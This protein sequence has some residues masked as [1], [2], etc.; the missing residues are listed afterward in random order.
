M[1]ADPW[2]VVSTQPADPWAV[3]SQTPVASPKAAAPPAPKAPGLDAPN[4]NP[5]HDFFNNGADD[6]LHHAYAWVKQ[7]NAGQPQ[8]T[9]PREPDLTSG[10]I[11]KANSVIGSD[12][13]DQIVHA[14]KSFQ[15]WQPLGAPTAHDNAVEAAAKLA[16]HALGSQIDPVRQ[17]GALGGAAAQGYQ[18]ALVNKPLSQAT[19]LPQSD[20]DTAMMA[21]SPG[22]GHAPAAPVEEAAAAPSGPQARLTGPKAAD[23]PPE[24]PVAARAADWNVVK[25]EPA[26]AQNDALTELEAQR[27]AGVAKLKAAYAAAK[28]D[29]PLVDTR[30][31]G[32]QYHGARGPI[33]QLQEGYYSP[34][35][36]YGGHDTFYTTDATD[37][38]KGYGRKNPNST[39]YSVAE[40]APVNFYDMEKPITPEEWAKLGGHSDFM[41]MA[42][43]EA[44]VDGHPNLRQVMDEARGLSQGEGLTKDDVQ[45]E[46]D[47]INQGLLQQGYGGMTHQGGLKTGSAPHT[48]KIYFEPWHQVELTPHEPAVGEGVRPKHQ[49]A[50]DAAHAELKPIQDQILAERAKA[51]PSI[52]APRLAADYDH[53]T[54][55]EP[56]PRG[57]PGRATGAPFTPDVP[58]W[59]VVKETPSIP[60]E[61]GPVLEPTPKGEADPLGGQMSRTEDALNR[62]VKN[63]DADKIEAKQYLE[64]QPPEITDP[65]VQEKLYHDVEGRMINPDAPLSPEVQAAHEAL[66]PWKDEEAQLGQK[67]AGMGYGEEH[68]IDPSAYVHRVAQGKG[69]FMDAALDPTERAGRD[70]VMGD[71]QGPGTRG[72]S[73]STSSQQARKFFVLEDAKGNRQ[74]VT[75]PDAAAKLQ[76][77]VPIMN[78]ATLEAVTPKPATTAE[79]EANTGYR[80][81][82]NALVN[83]VDN[84]LRLRRAARNAD[85]LEGLKGQLEKNGLVHYDQ[86]PGQPP[87]DYVRVTVPQFK[88]AFADPRI[89]HILNDFHGELARGGE[90]NQALS[91]INRALTGAIFITPI[92]HAWNVANHWAVARGFDWL[93]PGGYKSLMLDGGRAVRAVLTQNED[94]QRMLREG[95]GLMY[96]GVANRDFHTV[97]IKKLGGEILADP[98]GWAPVAKMFGFANPAALVKTI[99]RLSSKAL[100]SVNDMFMLQRQFELMRKGLPAREAIHEA[101]RDI[102]NYR[103]PSH[104]G[105]KNPANRALAEL[106]KNPNVLMFG[107]Y[108]YGQFRAYA[109]PIKDI[110]NSKL[111]ASQKAEA[112]GKLFVM[113][114]MATGVYPILDK[115]VQKLSGNKDASVHRGGGLSIPSAIAD[116]VSGKKSWGQM[117]SSIAQPSPVVEIG[118]ELLHGKDGLGRNIIEPQSSLKGKA[119]Q[120]AEYAASKVAPL[121]TAMQM[122]R[123]GGVPQALGNLAAI[124]LPRQQTA[125]GR[126]KSVRYDMRRAARREARDPLMGGH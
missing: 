48:V 53:A 114:A 37:V 124:S 105:G 76:S 125:V 117:T 71:R 46:F 99:Y 115:V 51:A 96:G 60:G 59:K 31:Q 47:S 89:A 22:K 63:A 113:A 92:P 8:A 108:R 41:S 38:A 16:L 5:V 110:F 4:G 111:S 40:K 101:E 94:Y 70:P 109:E 12:V 15:P 68:S 121:N 3:Q 102:P 83:T 84:V 85:V 116:K 93:K 118:T 1:A 23:V 61:P 54:A 28:A 107:R 55:Q 77:G 25:Q 79:I 58:P 24:V 29:P 119:A 13:V 52:S 35:N 126:A 34:D 32:V 27:Q 120:A 39:M 88:G 80:Y 87:A 57:A 91:K 9:T 104:I 30:G 66:K 62:L 20:I 90:L 21:L 10:G 112:S 74:F 44:G 2:A 49:A 69:S 78:P 56:L 82:K 50:I 103:V 26:P 33:D 86:T 18:D 14:A 95:S 43:D 42:Y 17:A 64:S 100:W 45:D 6:P 106:M 19:G 67:L 123:P 7:F 98:K 11:D 65:A 36:I 97:M 73:R 72:L 122:T 75:D 81:H